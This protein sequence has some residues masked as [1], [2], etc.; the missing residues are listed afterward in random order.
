MK[1]SKHR[2]LK[3]NC[4][5]APRT[6]A[7]LLLSSELHQHWQLAALGKVMAQRICQ[8]HKIHK[9]IQQ[10]SIWLC[11]ETSLERNNWRNTFYTPSSCSTD[12]TQPKKQ[13]PYKG[14]IFI[15]P[16]SI[17]ILIKNG[18][19]KS[20]R[21]SLVANFITK[22]SGEVEKHQDIMTQPAYL[23]RQQDHNLDKKPSEKETVWN[24]N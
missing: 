3:G 21:R 7:V 2:G 1:K 5:P 14:H 22:G 12:S 19:A 11:S 8:L 15:S 18:L 4:W 24:S 6:R 23:Q 20:W 13:L 9:P 16:S 10:P 17:W